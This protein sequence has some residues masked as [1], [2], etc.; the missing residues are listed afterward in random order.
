MWEEK[1]KKKPAEEPEEKT[2]TSGTETACSHSK[3]QLESN[4][5]LAETRRDRSLGSKFVCRE[6]GMTVDWTSH[7]VTEEKKEVE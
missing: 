2:I 4:Y 6:C 1:K 3:E 5:T 7:G